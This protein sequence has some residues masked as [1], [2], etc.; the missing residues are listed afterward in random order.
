MAYTGV[1]RTPNANWGVEDGGIAD[2][3][4]MNTCHGSDQ[5]VSYCVMVLDFLPSD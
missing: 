2:Q 3:E 1:P 5:F 4:T